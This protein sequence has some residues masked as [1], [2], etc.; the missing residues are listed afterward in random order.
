MT[1]MSRPTEATPASEAALARWQAPGAILSG[2]G[3]V[4]L[5]GDPA[6]GW[7]VEDWISSPVGGEHLLR[8]AEHDVTADDT[9][10]A[11]A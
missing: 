8:D 3:L 4:T 11:K 6:A 7:R 1:R 5:V 9:A 2:F 10:D